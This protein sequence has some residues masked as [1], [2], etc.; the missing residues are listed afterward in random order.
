MSENMALLSQEEIDTLI[1]F[2]LE[3]SGKG[4]VGEVLDQKS[5]DKLIMLLKAGPKNKLRFD[6]ETPY[7]VG[8]AFL[9]LDGNADAAEQRKNC[10]LECRINPNNGY[11]QVVCI[12]K[13][14]NKEYILTPTCLES[15][16][17]VKDD[18]EWGYAVPPLT[19]DKIASLLDVKYTKAAFD[20]V[21]E[22]YAKKM[23]GD[24]KHEVSSIYMPSANALIQ[25]LAD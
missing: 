2:I 12:N 24:G 5:I 23:Y 7:V 10:T 25:H 6:A 15:L 3:N 14:L 20:Y 11:A 4:E 22:L 21:C 1:E 9:V 17:Y 18:A 8:K 16:Q 13:A 19:F